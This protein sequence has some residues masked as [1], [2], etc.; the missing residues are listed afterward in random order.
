MWNG[1]VEINIEDLFIVLGPNLS[2]V[3]HDESYIEENDQ[4][5]DE[6][7]DSSNMFNIF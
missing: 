2:V 4:N 7:Y 3:S 5:L 6:S 1:P